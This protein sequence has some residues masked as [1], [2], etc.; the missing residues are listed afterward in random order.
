MSDL[1]TI[2]T[3]TN[4]TEATL[5]KDDL[6]ASGIKAVLVGEEGK[7]FVARAIR[8]EHDQITGGRG[9]RCA[10]EIIKSPAQF[11]GSEDELASEAENAEPGRRRRLSHQGGR[12]E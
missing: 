7:C 5:A 3:Y 10:A 1:V 9:R 8:N 12:T 6:I 11:T 2:A 4:T